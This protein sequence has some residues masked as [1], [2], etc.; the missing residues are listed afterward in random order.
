MNLD[1]SIPGDSSPGP[2]SRPPRGFVYFCEEQRQYHRGVRAW[3]FWVPYL[4]GIVLLEPR[5]LNAHGVS[6]IWWS[7]LALLGFLVL[8][9]PVWQTLLR[10]SGLWRGGGRLRGE[11][12]LDA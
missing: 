5:V 1:M 8:F 6:H 3:I 2:A 12:K 7:W 11:P 4:A 9:P 10:R